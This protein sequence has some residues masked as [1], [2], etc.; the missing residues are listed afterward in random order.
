MGSRVLVTGANGHVGLELCR[1]LAA[2]G[3]DIR[4]TVRDAQDPAKSG[5]LRRIGF[6]D[7]VS[8]DI[9]DGDRFA[10]VTKGAD[11]LFHVAATYRYWTGGAEADR[12]MIR[13][14]VEGATN[15]VRAAASTGVRRLV[16]TSSIVTLP[17][18]RSRA[19]KA[20][21]T[22]WR[23]DLRVPY[24]RAKTEAEQAA[25]RLAGELGVDM[26]AVLPGGIIGPFERRTTSIEVI[27]NVMRGSLR[28]GVPNTSFPAV[29]VRDV[30][31]GHILAAEKDCAGRFILC[32]DEQP[33]YAEL[34][35]EMRRIDPSVPKSWMV[36]PDAM[37]AA[38]PFF[39]WLNRRVLG[40]NRTAT[41][42]LMSSMRGQWWSY[43]NARARAVLGWH[44]SIPLERSLADTMSRLRELMFAAT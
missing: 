23:T 33:S 38:A 6:G 17:F 14:A 16:L 27:E 2:R 7:V 11:V 10:A 4:A 22:M 31:T 21:E 13:D 30:A 34:V 12:E 32:N 25:W 41:P 24:F 44:P 43:S 26:V 19:E 5:M 1:A 35:D 15:A 39:D 20:D 3:Y 42:A 40:T 37:L 18:T 28:T 9:R 29:D 36:L 8:L